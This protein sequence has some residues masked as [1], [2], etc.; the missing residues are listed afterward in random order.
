MRTASN[1]HTYRLFIVKDQLFQPTHQPDS[2][3]QPFSFIAN[4]SFCLSAAEKRDYE[5]LSLI[6]QLLFYFVLTAFFFNTH[7]ATS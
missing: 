1:A 3:D 2:P 5:L 6:R 4:K 7:S